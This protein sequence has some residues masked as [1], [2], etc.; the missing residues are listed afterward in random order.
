[1][2][3]RL[4]RLH[5][6]F[7]AE[8]SGVDLRNA[9]DVATLERIRGAMDEHAIL[10]FRGQPFTNDEQLAFAQRLDGE[11]HSKTGIGAL[12]KNRFGNE[13]LID[14]SNLNHEGRVMG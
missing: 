2:N 14:I 9:H 13:A 11:L 4:T 1:M 3:M 12:E 6:T 8:V 5:P 7:V 10:V